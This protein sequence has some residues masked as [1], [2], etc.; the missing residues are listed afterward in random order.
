MMIPAVVGSVALFGLG[1][2]VGRRATGA[3][4]LRLAWAAGAVAAVPGLLLVLYYTHLFDGAAWFYRFRALP[5]T[6]LTAGGLGFVAG[7]AHARLSADSAGK[8][9]VPIALALLVIVP[10]IKPILSPVQFGR[11][12]A[13]PADGTVLQSTF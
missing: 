5:G 12:R 8:I 7:L 11:P 6:E 9:L 2:I 1:R 3:P 4:A 13:Q 10:F